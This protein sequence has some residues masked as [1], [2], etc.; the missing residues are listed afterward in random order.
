MPAIL[1]SRRISGFSDFFDCLGDDVGEVGKLSRF[2]FEG[3][4]EED[5]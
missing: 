5:C 2:R 1:V 3:V 4:E